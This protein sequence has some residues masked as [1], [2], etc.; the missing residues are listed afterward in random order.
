MV[1]IITVLGI[2]A[3]GTVGLVGLSKSDSGAAVLEYGCWCT[4]NMATFYGQ[5]PV[6]HRQYLETSTLQTR[7]EC[8]N[9]CEQ[10]FPTGNR[11][12]IGEPA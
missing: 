1:L 12:V 3:V 8:Q 9:R 6:Q 2:L 5:T 4:I 7:E 10:F 11:V